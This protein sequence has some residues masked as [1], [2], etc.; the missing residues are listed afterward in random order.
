MLYRQTV[1]CQKEL[2]IVIFSV[3]ACQPSLQRREKSAWYLRKTNNVTI[4]MISRQKSLKCY[5]NIRKTEQTTWVWFQAQFFRNKERLKLIACVKRQGWK[6]LRKWWVSAEEVKDVKWRHF[7]K[8]CLEKANF[9]RISSNLSL[10]TIQESL[11]KI[12]LEH[13]KF[14]SCG[15]FL[16]GSDTFRLTLIPSTSSKSTFQALKLGSYFA[17]PYIWN[18]LKG[19]LLTESGS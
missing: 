4:S 14:R 16:E 12:S 15:P 8:N 18:I 19:Q 5:W 6:S 1:K 10:K 13:H 9:T 7:F 11:C 2:F 3:H 17:F